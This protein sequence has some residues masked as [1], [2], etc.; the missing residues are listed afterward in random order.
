MA[1]N[2]DCPSPSLADVLTDSEAAT[3]RAACEI[4]V[5]FW[6]KAADDT[7]EAGSAH[8]GLCVEQAAGHQR[9]LERIQ[10]ECVV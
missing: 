10:K 8:H 3:L 4:A 1:H 2:Q 5:D 7:G 6:T 9:M